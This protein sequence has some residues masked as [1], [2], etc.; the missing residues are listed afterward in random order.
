MA[1]MPHVCANLNTVGG[2]DRTRLFSLRKAMSRNCDPRVRSP[3]EQS[4]CQVLRAL[5]TQYPPKD[6]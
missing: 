5:Y 2:A 1:S 4:P 3:P 6:A